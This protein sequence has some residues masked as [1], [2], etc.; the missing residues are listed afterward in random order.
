MTGKQIYDP[1]EFS[2]AIKIITFTTIGSFISWRFLNS[3]YDNV[4]TPAID[5]LVNADGANKYCIKFG[6]YYLRAD[7]IIKEFIKWLILIL[8]LMLAYNL[9]NEQK[10]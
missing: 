4:C 1:F 9:I 2:N 6:D 7:I 10:N 8:L 3:I 5:T